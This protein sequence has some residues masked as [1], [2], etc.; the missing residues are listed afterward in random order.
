MLLALA[1][2]I[3]QPM[4]LAVGN[5]W[6][7][8]EAGETAAILEIVAS[9]MHDDRPARTLRI[10]GPALFWHTGDI[11]I[12]DDFKG[13][14]QQ[15]AYR[16]QSRQT[17]ETLPL[18]P[19][20]LT[21][22]KRWSCPDFDAHVA[23]FGPL[24]VPAGTFPA[25]RIDYVL[26]EH[27]GTEADLRIWIA[28][29]VGIVQY[30]HWQTSIRGQKQPI[31]EPHLLQLQEH[32]DLR[33]HAFED[34]LVLLPAEMSRAEGAIADLLGPAADAE[35]AEKIALLRELGRGVLPLLQARRD[36]PN[37]LPDQR[38]RIDQALAAFPK[39][40]LTATVKR[41]VAL[42]GDPKMRF[43]LHNDWF[44]ALTVLPSLDGSEHGRMPSYHI[45]L[46]GPDGEPVG[47]HLRSCIN[48]NPLTEN[49]FR[50]LRPGESID[51]FGPGTFSHQ[52]IDFFRPKR[53]GRYRARLVLD[54]TGAV[55][56][57]WQSD[58]DHPMSA[59]TKALLHKLPQG[60]F[61]SNEIVFDVE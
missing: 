60:R 16:Y 2:T 12:A 27:L 4:P 55:P 25:F 19:G 21:V 52:L 54:T 20:K 37:T 32:I 44:R 50:T 8:A 33:S 58:F 51:P 13:G 41:Q 17:S 48:T 39:L 5:R 24:T 49:D 53:A 23:S 35:R 6:T 29:N 3:Q 57:A 28:P 22:G 15:V 10:R 9:S 26:N 36:A 45:E 11:L 40:R 43:Q 7:F 46:I 56:A 31:D 34:K 38:A 14:L 47:L 18:L 1:L 59:G 30:E 61:E 42:G